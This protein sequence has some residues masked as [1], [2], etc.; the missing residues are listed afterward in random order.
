MIWSFFIFI[1]IILYSLI[2]Y[3]NRATVAVVLAN[4]TRILIIDLPRQVIY[5]VDRT[6][7]A[8]LLFASMG[9]FNRK[10][11]KMKKKKEEYVSSS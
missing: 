11:E 1:T 2:I 5:E 8:P 9:V 10:H 3:Y 6:P 7:V 4:H